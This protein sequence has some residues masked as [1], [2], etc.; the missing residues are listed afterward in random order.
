MNARDFDPDLLWLDHVHH[1]GLLIARS[2]LKEALGP[3]PIQTMV[4]SAEAAEW[5]DADRDAP[6]LRA[7]WRFFNEALRWPLSR[8]AGAPGGPALPDARTSVVLESLDTHLAAHWALLP[9]EQ[10]AP[11]DEIEPVLLVR[12]EAPGIDPD[13]RGVLAGWEATPQQ[14]FERLLR[15]TGVARGILVSDHE[16]RLVHAPKGETAGW[17]A[18]P[19]HDLISVAGRPMLGGLK[20]LLDAQTLLTAERSKRLPALLKAS[21]DAQANV[22]TQLAGQ[23]LGALYELL[24]GLRTDTALRGLVDELARR[25]PRHLYKGLLTVLMRLVFILFAEDRELIPSAQGTRAREVYAKS[26]AVCGLF[27][28]LLEDAALHPD[29]MDERVGGWG[30]LLALFRLIHAGHASG[31][32]QKR[33]GWFFDPD[34]FP[35][36]EGRAGTAA[37]PRVPR[38]G[39]GC[40]LR[41]LEGL[42]MLDGER[43]SYKTLDVEQIGSVYET[44]MGFAV[45]ITTGPS[46]AIKAGKHNR[47]PV[48]VDLD[49]L[50]LV[51]PADRK[52]RLAEQYNRLQLTTKQEGAIKDAADL[53]A[54]AIAL[55]PLVDERAS[56]RRV[57]TPAG[58]PILQPTDERRGTGSHYTPRSLTEP[59]VDQAL[60]PA[61]LAL[62]EDATP[63]AVLALKVCDPAMGSGAFLVAACRSLAERL[64]VAW[65]RHPDA[66]PALPEDE[67]EELHA[68]RLVAQ[69]C[70]YGVDKNPMAVDLARL[71]LWLATLARDHEF[72]FLD[73]ALKSGDSLV[74]L[75]RRQIERMTWE[76]PAVTEAAG[77]Q[78]E[79]F[80]PMVAERLSRVL[81]CRAEI[82]GAPDDVVRAEQEARHEI[83]EAQIDEVRRLGDATVATFFAADKSKAR[84]GA[85]A[86]LRVQASVA[87]DVE[88]WAAVDAARAGLRRGEIHPVRPFHWAIEFPEVFERENPGFD[89]IVGNPPFAGKNTIANSH[90]P[91]YI[92]WLQHIHAGAHGNADLVAHF[93]RRTFDL[94]RS[95]GALGLIASNTL[96]QGDTRATG[97][98]PILGAGGTI[99]RA[100]RRMKWPGEAAVVISTVHIGK[101]LPEGLVLPVELDGRLVARI[102]AYLVP[103]DNDDSP[104]VLKAN[105]GKSFQGSI[106]LGMGFTFDDTD[107]KGV[108][109]PIAEMHR[110][111]E[112]DP[113]NAEVIFPYIGGEEVN[114]SPTHAHHRYVINF[115]ERS[116]EACRERWPDLMAIVE[117][118][119]KLERAKLA[120]N[121]DGRRLK[122]YW[123]QFGRY[124]PALF[125]AIA[126]LNRV[127]VL[128]RVGEQLSIAGVPAG[129][130]LSDSLI[131][132]PI[133]TNATFC[134]IQSRPHELWARFFG[135]SLEDRLRYTPSDCFETFPFPANWETDPALEAAGLAYYEH[136]ANL[137]VANNE[138]LTKTY[139]R[140]H[141][142]LEHSQGIQ[143]L[144]DLHAAMDRAVLTAYGWADLAATAEPTFLTEDNE[145]YYAYQGRLFWPSDLRDEVLAR[146]LDLNRTRAAEE[147]AQSSAKPSRGTGRK[148]KNREAT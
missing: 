85:L 65:R 68:R 60:E 86:E 33:G 53:D 48:Y 136:R 63:D 94:L 142:P 129:S 58:T 125:A 31:F 117:A 4:D 1:E 123:W 121:P 116:E 132:F 41:I 124:R 84:K 22:S 32:M 50:L 54:L 70:L 88:L 11:G 145:P 51:K 89:A 74:G 108:A 100:T 27:E 10:P 110:L 42:L 127:L 49:D 66:R 133:Q 15:E 12:L 98:R 90:V 78:V 44:V 30:R 43:L 72:T 120:N 115:G 128:S 99:Y 101:R 71:S 75:T 134:A 143:T 16:L 20:L 64:M 114:T 9:K 112:Q 135:S 102:S 8:T 17:I 148:P 93:Y 25:D 38:V 45:Q 39:D 131:V 35:F 144:R 55:D 23:V 83:A 52:K 76:D 6:A 7:P 96:A 14:R 46:L 5:I 28:Q 81:V 107:K 111:I 106:V 77:T 29:T 56:P 141:N 130:V 61:L 67:D 21:R 122:Q 146:L 24:R 80:Q 82:Q 103:G 13:A 37:P 69:R 47:V 34:V 137:L 118:K 104:A 87:G 138:G 95:G 92:H 119:V 26:Y 139:N 19:L 3:P 62:G 18:W 79:I 109:T 57:R 91:G 147:A 36:L 126:G 73:H 59:I 2:V 40:L 105:A 140:F 113:R 97:L